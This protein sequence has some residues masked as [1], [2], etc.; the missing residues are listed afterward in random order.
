MDVVLWEEK[1][2]GIKKTFELRE[3]V[4]VYPFINLSDSYFSGQCCN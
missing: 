3:L 4:L 1:L 2:K